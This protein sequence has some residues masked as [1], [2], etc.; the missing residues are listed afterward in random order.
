MFDRVIKGRA[1]RSLHQRAGDGTSSI[2]HRTA[3]GSRRQSQIADTPA[4][5]RVVIV[6]NARCRFRSSARST[7]AFDETLR[8]AFAISG[9]LQTR[10]CRSMPGAVAVDVWNL[11]TAPS[12]VEIKR[13]LI[14]AESADDQRVP[15]A[16]SNPCFGSVPRLIC[17]TDLFC[18]Y[19]EIVRSSTDYRPGTSRVVSPDYQ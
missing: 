7:V 9:L 6:R 12:P 10:L 1:E 3:L 14:P 19:C 11:S 13:C 15:R 5:G 2:R 16:S 4:T 8:H 17:G 18:G